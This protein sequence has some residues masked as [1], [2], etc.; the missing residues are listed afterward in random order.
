M[1]LNRTLYITGEITEDSFVSFKKKVMNRLSENKKP[2]EVV[3]TSEGG[4]AYAALAY[5]DFIT[6]V[7]VDIHICATG[8]VASAAVVILAAGD[9]RR[10][11]RSAWV[12]C[13]EDQPEF[14]EEARVS[15][16]ER[17]IA[18]ARRMEDQWNM[19]LAFESKINPR[20]WARIHERETYLSAE[21][22]L[23]IGLIDEII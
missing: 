8:L 3:L 23:N 12:M 14:E 16:L 20:E 4:D 15:Q 6:S 11:T 21:E 19:L 13:H 1:S 17:D 10:M 22:C 18:H 5:Y 7:D 9:V 2:I